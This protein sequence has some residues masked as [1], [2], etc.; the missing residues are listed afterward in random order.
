MGGGGIKSQGVQSVMLGGVPSWLVDS[1]PHGQTLTSY[2]TVA[3]VAS[4]SGAAFGQAVQVGAGG[5][6]VGPHGATNAQGAIT[7]SGFSCEFILT[8]SVAIGGV[9]ASRVDTGNT[10]GYQWI[11]ESNGVGSIAVHVVAADG[12]L[13]NPLSFGGYSFASPGAP[14]QLSW[15]GSTIY[16]FYEGTLITSTSMTSV[17]AP[18]SGG[19]LT[20]GCNGVTM[21]EFCISSIARNTANY[22]TATA[23]WGSDANTGCLYHFDS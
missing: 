20:I 3:N 2:G 5:Y 9:Y 21:D 19:Y 17:W 6:L 12:S 10:Y 23:E 1:S 7:G 14:I 22:T 15:D 11:I 8:N 4:P 16:L 13:N 18:T